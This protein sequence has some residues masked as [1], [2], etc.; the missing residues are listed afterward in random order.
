MA[1]R[2]YTTTPVHIDKVVHADYKERLNKHPLGCVGIGDA[3]TK[4]IRKFLNG[5]LIDISHLDEE[6]ARDVRDLINT[7]TPE[8]VSN[9]ATKQPA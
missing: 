4:L 9:D 1:K 3:A 6:S 8:A 5:Q 2:E 7:R